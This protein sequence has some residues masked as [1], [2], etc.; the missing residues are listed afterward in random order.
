MNHPTG[1]LAAFVGNTR[2]EELSD[3]VVKKV[4]ECFQDTLGCILEGSKGEEFQ[5]AFTAMNLLGEGS[6]RIFGTDERTS[7]QNS[8]LLHALMAHATEFDDSHKQ[9]K[10]HPGAVIIPAALGAAWLHGKISG[11]QLIAS[12]A[13][14][15]EV[16]LR[17]GKALGAGEHRLKGWHATATCGIFGA[18]AAA[19][20]ILGLDAERIMS[21]LG[22]AGTQAAGIWAFTSDGSMSKP[23]HAGKA[24]QG[25]LISAVLAQTGFTGSRYILEAEDGGFFK[26]FAPYKTSDW[27]QELLHG[28]ESPDAYEI[29]NVAYKPYPCCR[30]THGAIEAALHIQQK[31]NVPV[32]Q[33]KRVVIRTYDVAV[34]QCGFS[35]PLNPRLA[36]FSFAYVVAVALRSKRPIVSADFSEQVFRDTEILELHRKVTV[37][38]SEEMDALFPKLWPCEVEVE[39]AAG[40]IYKHRVDIAKG[41]PL[42]PLS[43]VERVGKFRGC[44]DGVLPPSQIDG[45]V[46]AV[47]HLEDI[48]DLRPITELLISAKKIT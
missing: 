25:G 4:K 21:A 22:S 23:L 15:Y 40:E 17:L 47:N 31:Q 29:L 9:S 32:E 7:L 33:I 8:V 39:T 5:K 48:E 27:Q 43:D 44:A 36:A 30:T 37:E 1:R 18:A 19:A 38:R 2:Y 42:S 34:K 28:L 14:G 12:I 11:K 20:S 16:T 6:S 3:D 13:A 41:D 45:I 46:A 10:T 26:A 35:E 24:A